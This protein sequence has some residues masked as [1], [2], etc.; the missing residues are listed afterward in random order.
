M[1]H[2][3]TQLITVLALKISVSVAVCWISSTRVQVNAV[4]TN[5]TTLNQLISYNGFVYFVQNY[6]WWRKEQFKVQIDSDP[7]SAPIAIWPGMH[8]DSQEETFATTSISG[9]W[10]SPFIQITES[11]EFTSPDLSIN[12]GSMHYSITAIVIRGVR[13]WLLMAFP[14][15]WLLVRVLLRLRAS[16]RELLIRRA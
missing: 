8:V 14:A 7:G 16:Q 6:K 12:S 1:K 9:K 3:L 5:G 10:V 11:T 4:W 15:S 2:R 13:Y